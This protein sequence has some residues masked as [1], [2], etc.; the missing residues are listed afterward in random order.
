MHTP[1]N[2]DMSSIEI[3]VAITRRFVEGNDAHF[4]GMGRGKC[5][6][7]SAFLLSILNP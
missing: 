7:A 3:A 1:Y 2:I 5:A 4:P 6:N